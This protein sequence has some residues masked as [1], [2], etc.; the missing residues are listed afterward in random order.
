MGGSLR[1][2]V[3]LHKGTCLKMLGDIFGDAVNT[4]SRV[5]SSG[6]GGMLCLSEDVY[7]LLS[8]EERQTFRCE[9]YMSA[10]LK[11]KEKPLNIYQSQW[12]EV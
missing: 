2:R 10:E 5:E 11:G 1:N 8:G 9:F 4:A 6:R 3:G 12:E 7:N